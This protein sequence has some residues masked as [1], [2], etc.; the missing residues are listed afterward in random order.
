MLYKYT[1]QHRIIQEKELVGIVLNN[2]QQPNN[3][4]LTTQIH[5][6]VPAIVNSSVTHKLQL[7]F[8]NQHSVLRNTTTLTSTT[9]QISLGNCLTNFSSM[10][11]IYNSPCQSIAKKLFPKI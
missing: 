7:E 3:N 4:L 8:M 11:T 5:V 6:S 1:L 2:A 10:T 9:V